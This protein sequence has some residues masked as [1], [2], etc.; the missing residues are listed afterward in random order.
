[1]VL[2]VLSQIF[3]I[4]A[5]CHV[6][7]VFTQNFIYAMTMGS[8]WRR[9]T[10]CRWSTWLT[11][12]FSWLSDHIDPQPHVTLPHLRYGKISLGLSSLTIIVDQILLSAAPP[13]H[14]LDVNVDH[15][16]QLSWWSTCLL[17]WFTNF[18]FVSWVLGSPDRDLGWF[19]RSFVS[20]LAF[21]RRHNIFRRVKFSLTSQ[22][23]H[24]RKKH[25]LCFG[26]WIRS[27]FYAF[28]VKPLLPPFCKTFTSSWPPIQI[29]CSTSQA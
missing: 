13:D 20:S 2:L 23:W 25:M 8:A 12:W 17:P 10:A 27:S 5:R 29:A 4:I 28:L 16:I 21:V 15:S 22:N 9:G 26:L 1:M 7:D 11:V 19:W 24:F 6:C 14:L 18:F 3:F